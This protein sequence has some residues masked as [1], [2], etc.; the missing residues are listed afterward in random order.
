MFD[1]KKPYSRI[2]GD[3]RARYYQSGQYYDKHENK[4]TAAEAAEPSGR[5]SFQSH[6]DRE[7]KKRLQLSEAELNQTITLNDPENRQRQQKPDPVTAGEP[8]E[9]VESPG[10]VDPRLETLK[11]MTLKEL[12]QV[13]KSAQGEPFRGKLAKSRAVNWLLANTAA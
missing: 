5:G 10:E 7:V 12:N 6:V 4:L 9:Q 8:V 3:S 11:A 13:V 1:S 2:E